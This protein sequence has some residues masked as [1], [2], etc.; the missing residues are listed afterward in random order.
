MHE[1]DSS[2]NVLAGP[3]CAPEEWA[4]LVDERVALGA[5]EGVSP[6]I[7]QE[8]FEPYRTQVVPLYGRE[9]DFTAQPQLFGNLM[10]VFLHAGQFGG[11]YVRQG[12]YSVIGSARAGLVAPVLWVRD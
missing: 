11:V 10:G 7:V 2:K 3:D 12:P 5:H 1:R 4:R 9:E 8:F 6:F